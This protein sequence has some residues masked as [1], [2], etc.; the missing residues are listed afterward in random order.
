MASTYDIF[1]LVHNPVEATSS[2]QS[3]RIRS[4]PGQENCPGMGYSSGLPPHSPCPS[5]AIPPT[6]FETSMLSKI[7]VGR[8]SPHPYCSTQTKLQPLLGL[9]LSDAAQAAQVLPVTGSVISRFDYLSPLFFDIS[10]ANHCQYSDFGRRNKDIVLIDPN[11]TCITW[12]K[13]VSHN[14]SSNAHI[15]SIL[16]PTNIFAS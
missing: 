14:P 2:Y 9:P 8:R 7:K 13:L 3:G 10:W 6:V 1:K 15:S 4:C 11:D 5:P 12:P 16:A